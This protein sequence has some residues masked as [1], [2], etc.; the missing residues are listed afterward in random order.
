MAI[1]NITTPKD[2]YVKNNF[3]YTHYGFDK[4]ATLNFKMHTH[5]GYEIYIFVKGNA[6]YVI[7]NKIFPLKPYDILI[8]KNDELHQ[9]KHFS[10]N[11]P[12][13]RI[14]I[15]LN[16]D[17]LREYD[18]MPYRVILSERKS[19]TDNII[20]PNYSGKIKLTDCLHRIEKYMKELNDF[21]ET[22]VKCSIIELLHIINTLKSDEVKVKRNDDIQTIMEYIDDNLTENIKLDDIA[23]HMF[24]S[25]YHICRIFKEYT[26]ITVNKYITNK[27]IKLVQN[28]YAGGMSLSSASSHAG[29]SNYSAFYKSY[30]KETGKSPKTDIENYNLFNDAETQEKR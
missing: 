15:E 13:E 6:E 29:F 21:N 14:C 18:C 11:N 9:V 10:A 2:S 23:N 17:F 16:D 20:S 26:G 27:K 30:M 8:T 12:Y 22:I 25:K 28:L 4:P 24:M 5:T 1:L 3:L 7:N 19:D